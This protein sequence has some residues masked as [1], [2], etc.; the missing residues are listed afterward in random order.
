MVPVFI[1][2]GQCVK[3]LYNT[4]TLFYEALHR[5][6]CY[7]NMPTTHGSENSPVWHK[8]GCVEARFRTCD[9]YYTIM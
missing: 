1:A 2:L 3:I 7:H 5:V 8:T 6:V 4:N 9:L